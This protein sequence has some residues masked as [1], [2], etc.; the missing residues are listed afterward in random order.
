MAESSSDFGQVDGIGAEAVGPAGQRTFRL[1]ARGRNEYASMWM[2]KEQLAALGTALQ[3]QIVRMGR[4]LSGDRAPQL[5]QGRE[6]PA[7][8][9]VEFR[10]GQVGLG[11]DEEREQF[12]VF[13]YP[14]DAAEGDPAAWTGRLAIGQGRALS[15]EIDQIV[16]A[17]R[18][19]CPLCGL[20]MDGPTH[21]CP[22]TNGHAKELTGE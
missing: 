11:Y 15:R 19:K 12:I 5:M 7:S 18:P 13:A 9:D 4:P 3:Q 1:I 22:R 8:A 6:L 14:V 16:N 17:G 20:V 2:E 10:C 21:I